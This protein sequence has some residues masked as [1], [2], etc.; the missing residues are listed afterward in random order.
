MK[1]TLEK[2]L[3]QYYYKTSLCEIFPTYED[4]IQKWIIQRDKKTIEI[5]KEI[6]K[7][8]IFEIK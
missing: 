3:K 1:E 6:T 2:I 8:E 7:K 5:V 4:F